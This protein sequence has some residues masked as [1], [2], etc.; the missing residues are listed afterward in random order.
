MKRENGKI[1]LSA[2][3]LMK[4]QGCRHATTLDLQWLDRAGDYTGDAIRPAADSD[5][6]ELLQKKGDEHERAFLA[7]LRAAGVGVHEIK[8]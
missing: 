3:D 2:S 1:I 8:R 4:F 6:A 7:E 5:S